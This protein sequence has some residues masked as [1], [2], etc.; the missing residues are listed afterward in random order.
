MVI[1]IV[2]FLAAVSSVVH[3]DTLYKCSNSDGLITYTNQK[4]AGKQCT[5]L[6]KTPSSAP[7]SAGSTR[8]TQATPSGFPKVS[9]TQQR[10][11]DTDRRA[12]LEEELAAERK[13]LDALVP[14]VPESQE[15]RRH[16]E[17]N[18]EALK[19]ELEKL[20]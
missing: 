17:H 8:V 10:T 18:I 11:R 20:R 15:A 12:I 4:T 13:K 6:S 16:H 7:R 3:A 1:W 9:G 14:I 19:K 5:V 2:G